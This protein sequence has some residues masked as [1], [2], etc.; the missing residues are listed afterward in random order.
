[1]KHVQTTNQ[2]RQSVIEE[3]EAWFKSLCA[4]KINK[5]SAYIRYGMLASS[6]ASAIID[7]YMLNKRGLRQLPWGNPVSVVRYDCD[8]EGEIKVK[9]RVNSRKP[10][11][12]IR[13]AGTLYECSIASNVG[14][15][16]ESYA[17]WISIKAAVRKPWL[18]KALYIGPIKQDRHSKTFSGR[19]DKC[20]THQ[21]NL[22]FIICSVILQSVQEMAIGLYEAKLVFG[23]GIGITL[24]YRQETGTLRLRKMLLSISSKQL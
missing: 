4:W 23:L 8:P 1:M 14:M 19:I 9:S 21:S 13:A 11:K 6:R 7:I 3:K 22:V 24:N 2:N 12:W 17:L 20:S 10:M 18:L 16:T 15:W 5:S